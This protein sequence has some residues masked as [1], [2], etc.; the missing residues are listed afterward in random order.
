MV[1]YSQERTFQKVLKRFKIYKGELIKSGI[2]VGAAPKE[3]SKRTKIEKWL[4]GDWVSL[5]NT[6]L[7]WLAENS[8]SRNLWTVGRN[9]HEA[10]GRGGDWV[11]TK[12]VETWIQNTRIQV[13][14]DGMSR[15]YPEL[16]AY[17]KRMSDTRSPQSLRSLSIMGH[18]GWNRSVIFLQEIFLKFLSESKIL[19]QIFDSWATDLATPEKVDLDS[20]NASS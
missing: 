19:P 10:K 20:S 11:L 2:A 3:L 1:N 15:R 8:N 18:K 5:E 17:A 4:V 7:T 12:T 6:W 13:K 14:L 9:R 16:Y